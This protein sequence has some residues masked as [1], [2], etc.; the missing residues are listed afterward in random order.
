MQTEITT[1]TPLLD[2]DG[3]LV[4]IGWARYP[5]LESNLENAAFYPRMLRAF[6]FSRI[7]V[8]DYY[9]IFTPQRFFSA[10]IANL[11][12]AGNIFVY[13]L[14]FETG[15]LHEEGLVIPFGRGVTSQPP[16]RRDL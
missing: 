5:L 9:A 15:E 14:D 7:K 6:Q 4:Q 16:D 10:T 12:Y 13:T 11:G 3:N 1:T 2:N 8:W